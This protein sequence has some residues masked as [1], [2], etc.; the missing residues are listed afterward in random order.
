MYRAPRPGLVGRYQS[1]YVNYWTPTN[2]SNE[3]QQ[4]TRTSDIPLYWEALGYRKG[5]FARVRNISLTYRMPESVLSKIKVSSLAFYVNAVNPF[6]FHSASD[7]DPETIPYAESFTATTNN[8][9]P[10][11]YSFRSIILGV[12]L[13]L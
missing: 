7:Y 2:P 1:N 6:L 11:S 3:Y 13:G 10:N 8:T 5:S 12:R 4:P 9:G